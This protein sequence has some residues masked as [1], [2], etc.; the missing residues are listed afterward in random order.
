MTE[1]SQKLIRNFLHD[2]AATDIQ[3]ESHGLLGA[4]DN[5]N[6]TLL[7]FSFRF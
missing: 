5:A 4:D 3:S 7:V 2:S 1:I 6:H